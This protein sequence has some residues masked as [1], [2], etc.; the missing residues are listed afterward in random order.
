[1]DKDYENDRCKEWSTRDLINLTSRSV[2]LCCFVLS[3]L[4]VTISLYWGGYSDRYAVSSAISGTLAFLL[5]FVAWRYHNYWA[6]SLP[7]FVALMVYVSQLPPKEGQEF[8]A[9]IAF[10]FSHAVLI[11]ILWVAL[12]H[13]VLINELGKIQRS[14]N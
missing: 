8:T 6:N 12:F 1:M 14:A 9:A 3:V 2:Q 11:Y 7:T 5:S 13:K 10:Y 4:I